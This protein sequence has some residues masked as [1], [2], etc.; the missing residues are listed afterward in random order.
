[1]NPADRTHDDHDPTIVAA[2]AAD[3]L[4]GADRNRAEALVARCGECALL[5]ADLGAIAGATAA[6]PQVPRPRDF[7]LT[8]DDAARLRP[9]GWRGLVAAFGR[10]GVA[11]ARPLAIGLTTI[12]IVGLVLTAVPSQEVGSFFTGS[13]QSSRELAAPASGGTTAQ[14]GAGAG[15]G[16]LPS[17]GGPSAAP[18]AA[19]APVLLAPVAAS[20]AASPDLGA[21]QQSAPTTKSGAAPAPVQTAAPV[22]TAAPVANAGDSSAAGPP[23]QRL[24]SGAAEAGPNETSFGAG[25]GGPSPL[26]IGSAICLAAGLGILLGRSALRRRRSA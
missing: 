20:P 5:L 22:S 2:L 24:A 7:T 23:V 17:A 18:S 19:P 1:M 12:G 14:S 26:A 4:E 11:A 15:T 21:P 13:A 9:A 16:G 25:G 8:P 6:L 10:S 3:D